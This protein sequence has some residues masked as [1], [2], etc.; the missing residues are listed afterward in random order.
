MVLCGLKIL[1]ST[2]WYFSISFFSYLLFF[3][4]FECCF[5][6][7]RFDRE[8]YSYGSRV[9]CSRFFTHI[10]VFSR[11]GKG[12]ANEWVARSMT[13][14]YLGACFV[15]WKLWKYL[16]RGYL[17]FKI[18]VVSFR[19]VFEIVCLFYRYSTFK[20]SF[21]WWYFD[22]GKF[23]SSIN[24]YYYSLLEFFLNTSTW[25]RFSK[26]CIYFRG[27]YNHYLKNY[28]LEWNVGLKINTF[29]RQ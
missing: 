4:R 3:L 23:S 28:P 11:V 26:H 12:I 19:F 5:R 22:F 17:N 25:F 13:L 15:A 8:T 6:N 20:K 1:H 10:W 29:R 16:F 18:G 21:E 2:C 7:R 24:P 14:C 9:L 27:Y